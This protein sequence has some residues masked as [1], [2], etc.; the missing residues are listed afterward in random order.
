MDKEDLEAQSQKIGWLPLFAEAADNGRCRRPR[1]YWIK[2]I[3]LT[4]GSDL[5]PRQQVK[6]LDVAVALDKVEIKIVKPPPNLF[7]ESGAK[8]AA[9]NEEPFLTFTRPIMRQA[10]PES[11]AGVDRA[12]AKALQ[13]WRGDSF[14]LPPYAYEQ[15]N[16]AV[17]KSG[18]RR[19][20][21]AEQ[22]RMMGFTSSHLNLKGKMTH[23]N[24]Q[25]WS[26]TDVL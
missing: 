20:L 3:P 14:R 16:L 24:F 18:P 25:M 1:L 9:D 10:P 5:T 11:P 17:D 23:L 21:P 15:H 2:N 26:E 8:K 12:S 22:L 19:L 7:L 13:R 4:P 6:I